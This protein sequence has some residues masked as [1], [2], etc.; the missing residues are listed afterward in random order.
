MDLTQIRRTLLDGRTKGIPGSAVPFALHDI[1]TQGWNILREDLPLPVMVLRRSALDQN[2]QVFGDYLTAHDLSFA[3][4]G[5][6]TMAPQLFAEQLGMGAWGITAATVQ[7]AIVMHDAGVARVLL[8]NQLI[9]RANVAAIATIINADPGF[10]FTTYVDSPAQLGHLLR[11]L[12]GIPLVRPINLLI[13]V[14]VMGGRTGLRSM[15][16]A[17]VLAQALL[18]APSDRVRFRGVAAF[19]GVVPGADTSDAPIRVFADNVVA[20]AAAL[21]PALYADLDEF[22]LTGG[23]SSHFDLIA[24]AFKTLH[25]PVPIRVILRS[26]C[27]VTHD[28]GAYEAAQSAA[29]DDP[30]RGWKGKLHPAI[31]IWAYVQSRPETDLALLTM[32]KRDAPHDAGL[33]VPVSR[34]RPGTGWLD[35]GD[36]KV[37]ALNDQHAYVRLGEKSDWQVGDMIACG[38]SHPCTA[39]DKWRFIPVVDDDYTVIDGML[40]FF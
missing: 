38:I 36:A 3:P 27:Y 4:H 39:F 22:I 21:P 1:A 30:A 9:G 25:L 12:E 5:K 26:G 11:H 8:A 34:F 17:M 28:N 23:G 32:G 10:D 2:A 24:A 40:T 20:I 15:A 7:Q 35:A 6:T 29:R 16:E 37:F 13:E 18:D 14:G 33:P 19:E 31:Q